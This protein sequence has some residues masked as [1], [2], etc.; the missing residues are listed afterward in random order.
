MGFTYEYEWQSV[1]SSEGMVK[2]LNKVQVWVRA[3]RSKK[4][5]KALVAKIEDVGVEDNEGSA[6]PHVGCV[7][8]LRVVHPRRARLG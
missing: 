1:K 2:R 4:E 8:R 6:N 3:S 5:N 7:E